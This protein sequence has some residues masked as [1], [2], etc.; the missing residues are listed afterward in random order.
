[1]PPP[2]C[3]QSIVWEL[4]KT[5]SRLSSL[6]ETKRLSFFLTPPNSPK[7]HRKASGW[8]WTAA[9][10]TNVVVLFP[11]WVFSL[12]FLSFFNRWLS[13]ALALYIFFYRVYR[14]RQV[15]FS[16]DCKFTVVFL[17][18][19]CHRQENK[20]TARNS[21]LGSLSPHKLF[22]HLIKRNKDIMSGIWAGFWLSP[23]CPVQFCRSPAVLASYRKVIS[24]QV[25]LFLHT[26][27]WDN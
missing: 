19:K 22:L 12:F 17:C 14:V 23:S 2:L 20:V 10:A 1:M 8:R 13:L 18:L 26:P 16:S 21:A 11:S 15:R 27:S 3:F 25:W 6:T 7:C 5:L 9:A 4:N 24:K